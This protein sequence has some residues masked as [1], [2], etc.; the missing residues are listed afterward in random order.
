[1]KEYA[2]LQVYSNYSFLRGASSPEEL[3][4]TA[5]DYG[6]KAIAITDYN[7]VS[8][9]VKAHQ[10]AKK[11]GIQFIPAA[12]IDFIDGPSILCYPINRDAY[13][14]MTKLLSLGK[15]RAI[16]GGCFLFL[17]DFFNVFEFEKNKDQIIVVIISESFDNSF[18]RTLLRF[19]NRIKK[20]LYMAVSYQ[21]SGFD[22]KKIE[23]LNNISNEIRIPLVASNSVYAH[24]PSRQPLQDVLTCMRKRSTLKDIGYSLSA[25]AERHLKKPDEML[26]LFS[27]WPEMITHTLKIS[28]QCEFSLDELNY[29]YPINSLSK[30]LKP[31]DELNRLAWLGAKKRYPKGISK[32][33]YDQIEYELSLIH[34]LNFSLYFL[35]VYDIVNFANSNGILCQGRGSAANSVVCYCLGITAVD[36]TCIDLLFER[37]IS[38]NRHE[39]PDIDIDFENSR[40]EEVIQYIYNKYGRSYSGIT[41]TIIT[42]QAKSALREVGKVMG[43]MGDTIASLQ[44]LLWRRTWSQITPEEMKNSNLDFNNQVIRNCLFLSKE[45]IG[46][47]RYLSQHSGGMVMTLSRLDEIVP[48]SNASMSGRTVIEWDKDDLD[49]L[50]IM[51]IDILA[52]GMLSCIQ[53]CFKLIAKHHNKNLTLANIPSE[54]NIVYDMLCK[55]DSIGVFQVESRAQMSML[56]RLKPRNFYDLVIEVAIVRPGPIQ[57]NMVHP[58]LRRRNGLE[59]IDFP[60]KQFKKI[61][62]KTLGVPLFQEQAMKIAIVAAGFTAS[63]ADL[64]RRV[65]TSSNKSLEFNKIRE[66]FINGM[67]LNDYTLEFS[68]HCFKQIES[69]ANYGFPESHAA[70]FALLVYISAWLKCHYP[71]AFF[72]GL[73]NSQPI[74]FYAPAQIINDAKARGLEVL[75]VDVNFSNF[76]C[77][78]ENFNSKQLAIRLGLKQIKRFEFKDAKA[79]ISARN[80]KYFSIFELQQRSGLKKNALEKLAY[81]DSFGSMNI[82]RRQAMWMVASL[83][84]NPLPLFQFK[85]EI[86][87]QCNDMVIN[88]PRMSLSEEIVDDY[89]NFSFSLKSHPFNLFRQNLKAKGHVTNKALK[90]VPPNNLVRVAGLI[91]SYQSP[92]TAKGVMF[93]TI[94]DETAIANIVIW[95]NIFK[96]YRNLLINSSI[97]CFEGYVQH[98]GQVTHLICKTIFKLKV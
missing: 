15:R 79:L 30:E 62:G 38:I 12:R 81:G 61:L 24:H 95:P 67:I 35:T 7:S 91:T 48:I 51:K 31:K 90:K 73:L 43:L 65:L 5:A 6:L 57:G 40:R 2:E 4:I 76:E 93:I 74:G 98:E 47:P 21:Y 84:S 97:L 25:N 9:S 77:T 8:G 96:K 82:N 27:N 78:L 41:A 59:K 89:L 32:K 20:N 19:R 52:L 10:V 71:A 42:F 37:F 53:R 16:N 92:Q 54:D 88:F 13:G 66:R 56:P 87:K 33:V 39:P 72:C 63:E 11:L 45:I 44:N 94:E 49:A 36:P 22:I 55:A 26:R 86:Y 58:Y 80:K 18:K 64:L 34:K 28:S 68:E 70:S 1:M 29:E 50:G 46:F 23:K 14:Q 75:A 3:V 83:D 69:F 60:S 17:S 85:N